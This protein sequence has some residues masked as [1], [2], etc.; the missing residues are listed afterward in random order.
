MCA[1]SFMQGSDSVSW[2][3]W[4]FEFYQVPIPCLQGVCW[5]N[6]FCIWPLQCNPTQLTC[7]ASGMTSMTAS[8][9]SNILSKRHLNTLLAAVWKTTSS[10]QLQFVGP[11]TSRSLIVI[12][13]LI[14][15]HSIISE[16]QSRLYKLHSKW[17]ACRTWKPLVSSVL[18]QTLP[19]WCYFPQGRS[20]NIADAHG[21]PRLPVSH[22]I[23]SS[24]V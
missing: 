13:R 22:F 11:V 2:Q 24:I 7:W 14:V 4:S 1:T 10:C 23:S 6:S 17:P 21:I 3:T 18:P 8:W 15:D 9:W 5:S 20:C 12:G 16:R 19:Q